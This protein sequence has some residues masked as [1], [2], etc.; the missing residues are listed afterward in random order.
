MLEP[1]ATAFG[2]DHRVGASTSRSPTSPT[3]SGWRVLRAG[4]ERVLE[5]VRAAVEDWAQMRAPD[6]GA[7][8]RAAPAGAARGGPTSSPRPRPSSRWLADEHFTFL[9]YREYELGLGRD[10]AELSAVEG[11]GLGILRGASRHAGNDA[12]RQGAG[13]RPLAAPAG[14]DQG[15]L[16]RH[17]ASPVLSGLRRRQAV[18]RPTARVIGERRFLGLYTTTA[19]K[20]GRATIP[21]LRDKVERVLTHAAFP[22]DSHDAKGL[23]DILES[24]PATAGP[25]RRRGLVED[26]DGHPR[27]GRAPAGA[28]VRPPR[29]AG[30][31]RRPALLCLPRDRFNTENRQRAGRILAEAF[32]GAQVDWAPAALGVADR[33]RRL[34]RAHA[35]TASPTSYDVAEIEARIAETT[36]AWTDQLRAALIAAHGEQAGRGAA[37][38]ATDRHSRPATEPTG[39]RVGSGRHGAHR[40][41]GSRPGSRS[42]SI[43]RSPRRAQGIDALPAAQREAAC[44][45]PTSVPTFEHMGARSSTS[46]HM[47]SHPAGSSAGVDLRLRPARAT[48]GA[49]TRR[50]HVVC[51]TGHRGVARRPRGRPAQRPGPAA[52]G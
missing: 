8:H 15:Q 22:P 12:D 26:R 46:A 28:S 17:R 30:P 50:R 19:Y 9:G 32:G 10:V 14:A 31:V 4:V 51:R 49:S 2:F 34:R 27:A 1:G 11:S 25:D 40:G 21:L 41:A 24:F 16:A 39:R 38:R 42:S 5:E 35:P 29:P 13:P 45:C 44:R 20:T 52:P 7:G 36:R 6:D 43:Y 3:P 33:P 48:R 23:I 18:R 47:R 37:T